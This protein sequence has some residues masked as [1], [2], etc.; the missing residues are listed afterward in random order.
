M[1]D[2]GVEATRPLRS[3]ADV[4]KGDPVP[5]KAL[6]AFL[7][8]QLRTRAKESAHDFPERIL[9][10]GIVLLPLERNLSGQASKDQNPNVRVGDGRETFVRHWLKRNWGLSPFVFF[11]RCIENIF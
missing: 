3:G 4:P 2:S 6:H 10:L 9:R 1:Y 7:V 8:G 11:L 5:H